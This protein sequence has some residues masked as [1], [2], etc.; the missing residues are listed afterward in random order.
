M[1]HADPLCVFRGRVDG[2]IEHNL[3]ARER[4]DAVRPPP[5]KLLGVTGDGFGRAAGPP[6]LECY[7]DGPRSLTTPARR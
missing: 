5:D 4:D 6:L 3:L 1:V 2:P 7:T